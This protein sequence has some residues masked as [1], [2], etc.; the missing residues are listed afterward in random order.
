MIPNSR[1]HRIR[2]PRDLDERALVAGAR[3]GDEAA[4]R[5]LIRR[6]NP[7]LFRVARGIV[8]SDAE[9]EE[10]VQE[11][12]LSAFTRLSS[13]REEA[14]FSTW[15]TRIVL[16]TARMRRRAARPQEEY[17]TVAENE[18]PGADVLAFPARGTERPET[19]LAR[20]QVRAMLETA[21]ASLPDELRVV[22]LMREVE[23]MS[24]RDVAHHLSLNPV[25]VKTRL[26][27][28]RR[29]LK[30]ILESEVSAGFE[31]IFP[32]DGARCAGMAER[33]T[34][35]LKQDGVL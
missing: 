1:Q 23:G 7:R 4:V 29:R 9:A 33:V 14:R 17:D 12:Y 35:R 5:E 34:E 24:V 21:V 8:D 25:T 11:S 28:A 20:T 32:F 16:N 19:M 2:E 15:I 31:A 10:V 27:R 22:F 18:F 26:F 3:D 30:A 13:F 6:L